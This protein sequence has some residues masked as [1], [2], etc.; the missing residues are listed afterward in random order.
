M[1]RLG[2]LLPKPLVLSCRIDRCFVIQQGQGREREMSDELKPCPC[3]QTPESLGLA[4]NGAK[5]AYAYGDCCSEWHIEFRTQYHELDTDACMELAIEAWNESSR[6]AALAAEK[7]AHGQTFERLVNVGNVAEQVVQVLRAVEWVD[8]GP[9]V[10]YCTR[11]R[12]AQHYGHT[13][14]CPVGNVLAA[15]DEF[16]T[17]AK[18]VEAE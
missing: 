6:S 1:E 14:N 2:K 10:Q 8:D 5:W 3:G 11:C 15:Y 4:D 17:T 16:R 13:R 9:M 18:P 12:C 7:E